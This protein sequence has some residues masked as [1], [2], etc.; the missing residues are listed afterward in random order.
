MNKSQ[1]VQQIAQH[2]G[3]SKLDAQKTIDAFIRVASQTLAAG[4]KLT[5]TGLGTFSVSK[6]RERTGRNFRTGE[7]VKIAAKNSVKFTAA[8]ELCTNIQ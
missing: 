5:L 1:L 2:S 6:T 3:V 7:P 8:S 4:D